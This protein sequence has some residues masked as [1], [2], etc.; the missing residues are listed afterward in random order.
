MHWFEGSDDSFFL[1]QK[2]GPEPLS[3]DFTGKVLF[4]RSRNRQVPIKTFLM[5]NHIV[6]GVGNIYANEALFRTGIHPCKAAGKIRAAKYDELALHVK[7]VLTEAIASG[8]TTLKD[9]VNGENMPGYFKVNLAVYGRD[10]EPCN[11]CHSVIQ[12]IV[13]AQRAT[14][15]CVKC[16]K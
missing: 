10:G 4:T 1:L 15:F 3:E 14:F 5:N 6:V 7:A 12:R 13:I 2:L 9:Y 8:G 16:Q 11:H